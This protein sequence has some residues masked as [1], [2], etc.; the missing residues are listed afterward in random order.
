MNYC[1]RVEKCPKI[2]G[3]GNFSFENIKQF[4]DFLME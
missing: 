3:H 4:L 2:N 1:W